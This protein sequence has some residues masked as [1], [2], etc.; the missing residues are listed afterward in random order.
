MQLESATSMSHEG[1]GDARLSDT[2]RG[3]EKKVGWM[4]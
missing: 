1:G 4:G 2:K 3:E